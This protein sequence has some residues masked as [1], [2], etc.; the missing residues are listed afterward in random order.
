[1]N[2]IDEL[3]RALPTLTKSELKAA[4]RILNDP[5]IM[6]GSSITNLAK[7]TGSS[8]SAIIRMCQKLGYDGFAE[9]RFSFNRAMMAAESPSVEADHDDSNRLVDTYARY[10]HLIPQCLQGAIRRP[11]RGDRSGQAA[12]NLGVEQDVSERDAAFSSSDETRYFQ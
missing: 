2:P 10:M 11:R 3:R 12:C 8:N 4:E 6:L 7:L 9:F 5:N 1:M